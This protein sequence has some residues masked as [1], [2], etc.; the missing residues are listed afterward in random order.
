MEEEIKI[1]EY[2]RIKNGKIGKV[3]DITNVTGQK[4]KKY[5]IKWNID[6]VYYISEITIVKHNKNIINL[7]EEGDIIHYII[8]NISTT[9]ETKGYIEGYTDIKDKEQ[10][11]NMKE[12]KNCIILGVIT[13]EKIKDI[14]FKI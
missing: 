10:I 3:L 8:N 9:L 7:I 13:K 1:G 12:D 14:E 6:E 5:L 4:R 2:V 11:K